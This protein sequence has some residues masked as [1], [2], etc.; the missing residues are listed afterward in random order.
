MDQCLDLLGIIETNKTLET[1]VK[2]TRPAIDEVL[3]HAM[4]TAQICAEDDSKAIKASIQT[5]L[6]EYSQLEKESKKYKCNPSVVKLHVDVV[7]DKLCI[8]ES[9]INTAVLRIS[10]NVCI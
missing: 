1:D 4:S 3:A 5:V 10:L 6:H 9:R 7:S 2:N 8:L